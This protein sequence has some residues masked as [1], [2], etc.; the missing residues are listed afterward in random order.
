MDNNCGKCKRLDAGR[1]FAWKLYYQLLEE[2]FE[3]SQK[4]NQLLRQFQE[5]ESKNDFILPPHFKDEMVQCLKELECPICMETM[6]KET[7]NYTQCFHKVCKKCVEQIKNT[8]KECPICRKKM[9]F[10]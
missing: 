7:F 3:L 10:Y 2:Q 9:K 4:H 6:T 5:I 8:S 1:R